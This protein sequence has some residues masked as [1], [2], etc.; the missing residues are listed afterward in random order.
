MA[1]S[2][3]GQ[4]ESRSSTGSA[5][6]AD[7]SKQQKVFN[8]EIA[9]LCIAIAGADGFRKIDAVV[10]E[11]MAKLIKETA[12][13]L[14]VKH[15]SNNNKA[16]SLT[17]IPNT[18]T[19]T[20]H[21]AKAVAQDITN[22]SLGYNI[23]ELATKILATNMFP[24]NCTIKHSIDEKNK[25]L[26]LQVFDE[27][28]NN[29]ATWSGH[30]LL[31]PNVI[32]SEL[33]KSFKQYQTESL[34]KLDNYPVMDA[35]NRYMI[36][37][38]PAQ[39]DR[40]SHTFEIDTESNGAF[41]KVIGVK[42]EE[43]RHVANFDW[44]LFLS[45]YNSDKNKALKELK[46]T[47][48]NFLSALRQQKTA[49]QE[50]DRE[51]NK[52]QENLCQLN[53]DITKSDIKE[54]N[55]TMVADG[56]D[57][58]S[59]YLCVAKGK[60]GITGDVYKVKLDKD[61]LASLN[62]ETDIDRIKEILYKAC[63]PNTAEF[64]TH[65]LQYYVHKLLL[66]NRKTD[67]RQAGE[68]S[69]IF[70][71]T[72]YKKDQIKFDQTRVPS[73]LDKKE[74]KTT[75]EAAQAENAQ[76][77]EQSSKPIDPKIA[78]KLIE[79]AIK[80]LMA[81]NQNKKEKDKALE[82]LKNILKE[83]LSHNDIAIINHKD[84]VSIET[85]K[86]K[87][88]IVI[89]R[90]KVEMTRVELEPSVAAEVLVNKIS[91]SIQKRTNQEVQDFIHANKIAVAN[92]T[93]LAN[94]SQHISTHTVRVNPDDQGRS[95]NI[96]DSEGQKIASI[97]LLK[98]MEEDQKSKGK[99]STD[100]A[101]N[102][103][104]FFTV[105]KATEENHLLKNFSEK[106][107]QIN[108]SE[109]R[110]FS[111]GVTFDKDNKYYLSIFAGNEIT[112]APK[113][114]LFLLTPDEINAI[115]RASEENKL[116]LELYKAICTSENIESY[117]GLPKELEYLVYNALAKP[118]RIE[119][120]QP[121]D[122]G[123][124]STGTWTGSVSGTGRS[125]RTQPTRSMPDFT[126]AQA[127]EEKDKDMDLLTALSELGTAADKAKA[128]ESVSAADVVLYASTITTAAAASPTL[129]IRSQTT[130]LSITT[131]TP[132]PGAAVITAAS[133]PK[134]STLARPPIATPRNVEGAASANSSSTTGTSSTTATTAAAAPKLSPQPKPRNLHL[135]VSKPT[136]SAAITTGADKAN[137]SSA[138]SA[139]STFANSLSIT[140]GD[141]PLAEDLTAAM[142]QA[143]AAVKLA[144]AMKKGRHDSTSKDSSTHL[145]G[146]RATNAGRGRGARGRGNGQPPK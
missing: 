59:Y 137:A 34:N 12:G 101:K 96:L 134:Y 141:N 80:A 6:A 46:K 27:N 28:Q 129:P 83:Y 13:L 114:H 133:T 132:S 94:P 35:I 21:I 140:M 82:L 39:D 127:N 106:I 143:T 29:I 120:K 145:V 98:Y 79:G 118:A 22:N 58:G 113:I 119:R 19:Y 38:N 110:K 146:A 86:N 122:Y 3:Q 69:T 144:N 102:P 62:K 95:A 85:E 131:K 10:D 100:F 123:S 88:H 74:K 73:T 90:G 37:L 42:E 52:A 117:L 64:L 51:Y 32:L 5:T 30:P 57:A 121:Y 136:D 84:E 8:Q 124:V 128:A 4:Q 72:E 66:N 9:E 142:D 65:P 81:H 116:K 56:S 138:T 103:Y 87:T 91:A 47:P 139:R 92:L 26:T 112:K 97:D 68:Q 50:N 11:D 115:N 99:A 25:Q 31:G 78:D 53:Q 60:L 33:E 75:T 63:K 43:E 49:S 54:I 36:L 44:S 17:N 93:V 77:I 24:I 61:I 48:Q 14:D 7:K 40:E 135:A 111:F 70:S 108:K 23:K 2:R 105:E 16:N 18:S 1:A 67:R 126:L 41:L 20:A 125:S 130:T 104:N 71:I 76:P 55:F 89:S 107:V 109:E 45:Q 15:K